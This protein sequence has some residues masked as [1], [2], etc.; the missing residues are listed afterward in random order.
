SKLFTTILDACKTKI[1]L[2]NVNAQGENYIPI[3]EKFGLNRREIEIIA[4]STPKKEYYLKSEVGARKF[5]LALGEKSLKLLAS[6]SQENQN[7]ALEIYK[8]CGNRD[9]FTKKFL[10]LKDGEV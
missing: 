4:V 2:P 1:F 8:R 7:L 9:E 10:N 6:S 3:Y 5:S